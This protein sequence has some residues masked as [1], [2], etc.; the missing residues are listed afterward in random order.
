M[1]AVEMK[2]INPSLGCVPLFSAGTALCVHVVEMDRVDS[3][4]G[5]P[6]RDLA[7]SPLAGE[8]TGTKN[9]IRREGKIRVEGGVYSPEAGALACIFPEEVSVRA[10]PQIAAGVDY[11]RRVLAGKIN[12]KVGCVHGGFSIVFPGKGIWKP[13]GLSACLRQQQQEEGEGEEVAAFHD[14]HL[15]TE[16]VLSVLAVFAVWPVRH[17]S[18]CGFE[19]RTLPHDHGPVCSRLESCDATSHERCAG[20]LF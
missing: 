6:P 18:A 13:A 5:E 20:F 19:I 16:G 14:R 10:S 15:N 11:C 12:Q 9:G 17:I 2:R 4:L 3:Q 8:L 1:P 7:G